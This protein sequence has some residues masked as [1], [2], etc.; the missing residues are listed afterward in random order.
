MNKSLSFLQLEHLI[1]GEQMMVK[2]FGLNIMRNPSS[3]LLIIP[4]TCKCWKMTWPV[5]TNAEPSSF[6]VWHQSSS[7][8]ASNSA[9]PKV[10]AFVRANSQQP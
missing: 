4:Q 2:V 3:L 9:S 5:T 7:N 6:C 8:N 1:A 10:L